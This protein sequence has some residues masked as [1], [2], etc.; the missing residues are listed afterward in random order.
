M[1]DDLV[2]LFSGWYL[3]FI[4]DVQNVIMYRV[5][6]Y[7]YDGNGYSYIEN[8]VV[9]EVWSAYVPWEY[10]IGAVVLVVMVAIVFKTLRSILCK[11]L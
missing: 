3:D 8:D 7:Q 10:L 9:P 11:I 1:F 4:V 5:G 6:N 2:A